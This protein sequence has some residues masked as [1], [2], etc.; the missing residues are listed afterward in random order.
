MAVAGLL[1]VVLGA[2]AATLALTHPFG[3]SQA[4]AAMT[5]NGAATTLATVTRQT[6]TSQTPVSGTLGHAGSYTVVAPSGTTAQALTQAQQQLATAQASLAADRTAAADTAAANDQTITQDQNAISAAQTQLNNDQAAENSDCAQPT[7]QACN[8]DKQAVAADGKA[9]TQAQSALAAAQVQVSQSQH[10]STAK[11]S[12]D[13]SAVHNAQTAFSSAEAGAVNPG[14]TY[15]AL[16]AVG[17]TVSQGEALYEV[18]GVAVPLFYG[19]V[20][21]WRAFAVGMSDGPD[22][23]ALTANLVALGFGDGLS[24]SN[25]FSAAT[26]AA[27]KRWQ[28]SIGAPQTG[29]IALGEVVFEPGQVV[30]TSVTPVVGATLQPGAILQASSTTPQVKVALD[31]AQQTEVKVG[32]Q[33]TITLPNSHTTTGT[34]AYVGTVATTPSSSAGSNPTPTVEVDITLTNPTA[35]GGLDQAPVQ[36]S[37]TTA[38]AQ[39]ALVVPVAALLALS[40]GGYAVEVVDSHG[41]HHLIAVAPGLFDDTSGLVQ[42]SGNGLQPGDRVVV[43]TT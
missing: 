36:V 8:S 33:V 42:V 19:S 25:H 9:L 15:T 6:L 24:Q 37:I 14:T 4:N 41:A 43:P 3:G 38:T 16:P 12:V 1:V 23:G 32:D 13:Q 21:P 18:S 40:G 35:S 22:V 26:Q 5:D 29:V 39:D 11:L 7:S 28:T 30:V 17:K 20:T 27:I 34:V 10:Q 31:A 2:A